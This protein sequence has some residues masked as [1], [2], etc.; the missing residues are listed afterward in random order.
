MSRS[1]ASTYD[2]IIFP[3]LSRYTRESVGTRYGSGGGRDVDNDTTEDVTTLKVS[4]M[5]AKYLE[6]STSKCN[7]AFVIYIKTGGVPVF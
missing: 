1:Q 6:L 4:N 5:K 7:R 2:P 3:F